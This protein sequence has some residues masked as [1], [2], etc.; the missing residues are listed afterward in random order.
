[1]EKYA[2]IVA[3]GEGT[4][5]GGGLPKQFRD[6]DGHPLLW[7]AMT[8][9]H[10][11]DPETRIILVVNE[12]YIADWKNICLAMDPDDFIDH[13]ICRGGNSRTTSVKNG[14]ALVP[15][16]EESLVAIHD[17]ARPLVSPLMIARGWKAV[18]ET[19]GAVPAVPV[20]DSLRH[21][22]E[23]GSHSVIR[24]EFVAVQTPQVFKSTMLKEAY[25]SDPD[26][27][28]SDDAAAFEAAGHKITLFN[29]DHSNIKVT[30]PGDMEIASLLLKSR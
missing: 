9:F 30:N 8:A 17:A 25:A 11:E 28:Y 26:T 14:L 16:A 27:T 19:G 29:G 12:K 7:W 22:D 15:D 3:G 1:M 23:G 10:N 13:E 6:L 18:W 24:S 20:T 5:L 2:I 21:L 4:R